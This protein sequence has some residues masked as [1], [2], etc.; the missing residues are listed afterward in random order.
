MLA[1]GSIGSLAAPERIGLLLR[2]NGVLVAA[3]AIGTVA[4]LADPTLV[5]RVP[6]PRS[7]EAIAVLVLSSL[8]LAVVA[9]R[10][11]RTWRLTRRTGDLAV[12]LGVVWLEAAAVG[13]TL[14]RYDQLGW[15]LGHACELVAICVVCAVVALDL[16]RLIASRPLAGDLPATALV[17]DAEQFLGAQ[18]ERDSSATSRSRTTP[19]RSTPG[20]WRC[21]PCCSA[22]RWGSAR[23]G[24]G[25]WPSV[26]CCTTSASCR[27]RTPC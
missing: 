26:A 1:I 25:R 20:A 4:G 7:D 22:R 24:C 23:A 27:S 13:A 9:V 21:T 17:R 6:Q 16:R 15:W 8:A 14:Y 18:R 11:G 2:L 5:P 19:P 12:L 10:A 3:I